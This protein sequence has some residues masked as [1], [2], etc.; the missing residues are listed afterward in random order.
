MNTYKKN[1]ST[2]ERRREFDLAEYYNFEAFVLALLST[3]VESQ[4]KQFYADSRFLKQQVGLQADG[5]AP[6]GFDHFET[7]VFVECVL[8]LSK[9]RLIE[10]LRRYDSTWSRYRAVGNPASERATL[11]IVSDRTFDSHILNL[12][13]TYSPASSE[14]DMVIWGSKELNW[15]ADRYPIVAQDVLENLLKVRVEKALKSSDVD[16][17]AEQAV[18]I[19]KL[20]ERFSSGQFALF[21]GAGV[22]SSAGM[23]DWNSL[24]NALF[25]TYLTNGTGNVSEEQVLELVKRMQSLD[26]P[27]ALV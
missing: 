27:S 17:K 3:H 20:A 2:F 19:A 7:P 16:W 9:D 10:I 6:G 23:P 26:A 14:L 22:S 11:L 4:G 13:K 21:L 12:V 18:R 25:V 24:L 1:G 8:A 5:F 15:L